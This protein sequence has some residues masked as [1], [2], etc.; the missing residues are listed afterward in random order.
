MPIDTTNLTG[1][2]T[3]MLRQ[4]WESKPAHGVPRRNLFTQSAT[5]LS[6]DDFYIS[7][8]SESLTVTV[9]G[10]TVSV[11]AMLDLD[12][13]PVDAEEIYRL[14]CEDAK[15]QGKGH[16]LVRRS[17]DLVLLGWQDFLSVIPTPAERDEIHELIGYDL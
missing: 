16:R 15:A 3:E 13:V 17:R 4:T 9:G 5:V 10:H 7:L 6:L 12:R 2:D 14:L 11:Y 8:G 1:L